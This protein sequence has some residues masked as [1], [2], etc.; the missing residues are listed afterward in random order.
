MGKGVSALQNVLFLKCAREYGMLAYWNNLIR[1]PGETAE[2][3]AR[4][5]YLIPK[6]IHL[7]PPIGGNPKIELHRFSPYFFHRG[8]WTEN[9]RPMDW[10]KGLFPEQRVDLSRTAY[11]FDADWKNTLG[12][13]AYGGVIKATQEWIRTWREESD[14]PRLVM[15]QSSGGGLKIVSTETEPGSLTRWKPASIKP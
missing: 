3:Y 2:D 14:L 6:L 11:F 9:L 13:D 10:Y 12:D 7:Q 4:M 5:E 8:K 15:T 1:V